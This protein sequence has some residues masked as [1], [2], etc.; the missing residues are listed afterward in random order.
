MFQS[1]SRRPLVTE[2]ATGNGYVGGGYV[3]ERFISTG[4]A[5]KKTKSQRKDKRRQSSVSLYYDDSNVVLPAQTKKR[6]KAYYRKQKTKQQAKQESIRQRTFRAEPER[7]KESKWGLVRTMT[8][9]LCKTEE[10]DLKKKFGNNKAF[11]DYIDR[12]YNQI[13][14]DKLV[15]YNNDDH[16][17]VV[18]GMPRQNTV[19]YPSPMV[20]SQSLPR[21]MD[22]TYM[23]KP[24]LAETEDAVRRIESDRARYS[25]SYDGEF[26]KIAEQADQESPKTMEFGSAVK[27]AVRQRRAAALRG[28]AFL[29]RMQSE[30]S[31][32]SQIKDEADKQSS[33]SSISESNH[34]VSD[35][36]PSF[37]SES[38]FESNY[39]SESDSETAAISETDSASVTDSESS[40]DSQYYPSHGNHGIESDATAQT[41]EDEIETMKYPGLNPENLR[42][43]SRVSA[44]QAKIQ[45]S[46]SREA[47]PKSRQWPA[48]PMSLR[49]ITDR[50]QQF[51][52]NNSMV[53]SAITPA[54]SRRHSFAAASPMAS[55]GLPTM[56]GLVEAT[57]RAN[58][59]SRKQSFAVESP[60]GAAAVAA[61]P[62]RFAAPGHLVELVESTIEQR[63]KPLMHRQ[64]SKRASASA[65]A[66]EFESLMG[67]Q[68]S[69]RK[70]SLLSNPA[71]LAQ[72]HKRRGSSAYLGAMVDA[73]K[74]WSGS[75]SDSDSD[76]DS[77]YS[78]GT[79]YSS[80]DSY[81][82]SSLPSGYFPTDV[83][84]VIEES[85]LERLD[86]LAKDKR[87]D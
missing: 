57:V 31:Q 12:A 64:F 25:Y 42:K 68:D 13:I 33:S 3:G 52:R 1:R 86:R 15:H 67:R 11:K 53:H 61:S 10:Y 30:K 36:A 6:T 56:L 5:T 16:Q 9:L 43:N 40:A 58:S 59:L 7:P 23:L 63:K 26:P 49:S 84:S 34:S 41:D 17:E 50:I 28:N 65:L 87:I 37:E 76:S 70:N 19:S 14:P 66:E 27:S 46:K 4:S 21:S 22:T 44:W 32:E 2:R 24:T 73:N 82:L 81:N 39:D 77:D 60:A 83:T 79:D 74:F 80:L 55:R 48:S 62:L 75:S 85:D 47:T 78:D 71:R 51:S 20:R 35:S 38:S 29:R 72:W 54:L 18:N 45:A 69:R 8:N